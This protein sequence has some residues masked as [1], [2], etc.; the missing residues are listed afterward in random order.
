M[1]YFAIFTTLLFSSQTFAETSRIENLKQLYESKN[2][3][4][5]QEIIHEILNS[6]EKQNINPD[7]ENFPT[8]QDITDE[9]QSENISQTD[10]EE[11]LFALFFDGLILIEQNEYAKAEESFSKI[12]E[13]KNDWEQISEVYYWLAQVSFL[14]KKFSQGIEFLKTIDPEKISYEEINN[15][16]QNFLSGEIDD[17][18]LNRCV[19]KNPDNDFIVEKWLDRQRQSSFA[20]QYMWLINYFL[21]NDKYHKYKKSF[22]NKVKIKKKGK[23]NIAILL[24]LDLDNS[25]KNSHSYDFYNLFS[26]ALKDFSDK[27][28][29]AIHFYDTKKNTD[30]LKEI[31]ALEELKNMDV[32]INTSK[33]NLDE[34]SQFSKDNEILLYDFSTKN[35]HAI[36]DNDFAFL[37]QTS[38][39]TYNLGAAKLILEEIQKSQG[40]QNVTIVHLA[41]DN[42]AE[43]FI[44]YLNFHH[45]KVNDIP[46]TQEDLKNVLYQ[47]RVNLNT[48][49]KEKAKKLKA[50]QLLEEQKTS[51]EEQSVIIEE[52]KEEEKE[53]EK[54]EIIKILEDSNYIFVGSPNM[55]LMGN[56]IGITEQL[57]ISPKIFCDYELLNTNLAE[58]IFH[59]ENIFYLTS[60]DFGYDDICFLNFKSQYFDQ[61]K[62][63]PTL[64]MFF[65][66]NAFQNIL[67]NILQNKIGIFHDKQKISVISF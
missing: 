49:K 41:E 62:K 21:H 64:K 3:Q 20:D 46:L 17:I 59:R 52:N 16:I 66:Y 40:N 24:P 6:N 35:L 32:I 65:N 56:V 48:I 38:Q 13:L 39:E 43:I 23:Y 51:E 5:A 60:N 14:Q 28:K 45:A 11:Q 44:N 12:V 55:V 37:T 25:P 57:N 9:N 26:M 19:C 15:I 34:V 10:E 54:L 8:Q 61:F 22:C 30:S 1:K 47:V 33:K 53:T 36:N 31:L 4:Q 29:F 18:E 58:E 2:F 50:Q 27:D 42:N 67:D 63:Y 7:E